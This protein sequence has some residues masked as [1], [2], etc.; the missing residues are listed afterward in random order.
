LN[1][2]VELGDERELH[3]AQQHPDLLP[4]HRDLLEI[5]LA[6]PDQVR[7][8]KRLRAARLFTRYYAN[9]KNGKHVTVV[10]ATDISSARHWIVTAYIARKLAEGEAEWVRN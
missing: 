4:E 1:A 9:L 5:T 7:L 3:I 2:D 8:S 6:D 10:V